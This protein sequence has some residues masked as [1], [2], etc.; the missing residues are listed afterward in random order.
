MNKVIIFVC[1]LFICLLLVGIG[2]LYFQKN[3]LK[4]E[5]SVINTLHEQ[6]VREILARINDTKVHILKVYDTIEI[7]KKVYI[8]K[9]EE[10]MAETRDK[11]VLRLDSNL[12]KYALT[13]DITLKDTLFVL[14]HR[15]DMVCMVDT[16]IAVLCNRV[17]NEKDYAKNLVSLKDSIISYQDTLIRQYDVLQKEN[18]QHYNQLQEQVV[19][20]GK[21]CTLLSKKIK[22]LK[23]QRNI[24]M[25]ANLGFILYFLI[26]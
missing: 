22:R 13:L 4:K 3:K 17:F 11:A 23:N 26:P 12:R 2:I 1:L 8:Q 7:A 15:E 5:I 18:A 10:I 9:N 20:Y 16:Q 24:S 25:A 21:E 14:N 19:S 6:T